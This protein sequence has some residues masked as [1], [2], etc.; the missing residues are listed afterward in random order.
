MKTLDPRQILQPTLLEGV[1]NKK[2]EQQLDFN[3]MFPEVKTDALG[4]TY[5]QDTNSAGDDIANDIQAN[6]S[7]LLEAAEL[8]EIEMSK[9]EYK[10]GVLRGFGYK[11]KFTKKQFRQADI[12]DEISRAVDRAVFGVTKK[13]NDDRIN[14]IKKVKNDVTEVGGAVDWSSNDANPISDILN[15]MKAS[16][17][18]GY[19]YQLNNLFLHNDNYFEL[20]DYIQNRDIQWVQ[21]P[22]RADT[23]IPNI[24]GVLVH[25]LMTAQIDEGDY[26]GIDSRFPGIT[27]YKYLDPDHSTIENGKINVNKIEGEEYPYN[28]TIEI[29]AEEG[30]AT[31][32][33]N[34]LYYKADAI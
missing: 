23:K 9:I 28:T 20:L 1:I 22:F 27:G 29:Y 17:I 32:L 13:M 25:N 33:P 4:F 5:G 18:E 24:N 7:E 16:K 3:G 11:I 21:S 12:I 30:L 19:P 8:D 6:P 26:A 14:T 31:K 10:S 2:M 34:T 15:I